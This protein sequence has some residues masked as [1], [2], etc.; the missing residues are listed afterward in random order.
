MRNFRT[1]FVASLMLSFA[2]FYIPGCDEVKTEQSEVLHEEAEVANLIFTPS[3]HDIHIEEK[4]SFDTGI[5]VSDKASIGATDIYGRKGVAVGDKVISST[6][7]P[8]RYGVL[9]R[10]QHGTFVSEGPDVRHKTM[11]QT[12][13]QGQKVDV[14]YKEIYRCTYSDQDKDGKKELVKRVLVD[15]DFLDARPLENR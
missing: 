13:K 2:M 1:L 6:D 14:L 15:L 5:G 8:E 10:C 12:L 3:R 11:W 9:F 4:S 7:V